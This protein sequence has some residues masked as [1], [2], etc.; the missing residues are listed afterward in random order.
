MTIAYGALF[1]ILTA[2]I[3][4]AIRRVLTFRT[5]LPLWA[6]VSAA[7][8]LSIGASAGLVWLAAAA[9]DTPPCITFTPDPSGK[10]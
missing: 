6:A 2:L 8:L 5:G 9:S 10:C 7:A 1:V 4:G 3:F